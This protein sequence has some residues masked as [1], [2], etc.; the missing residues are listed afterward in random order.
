MAKLVWRQQEVIELSEAEKKRLVDELKNKSISEEHAINN[1]IAKRIKH[2]I[3]VS[4]NGSRLKLEKDGDEYYLDIYGVKFYY[5]GTDGKLTGSAIATGVALEFL[6]K[7]LLRLS[8]HVV[9]K[10]VEGGTRYE[11]YKGEAE[12][13][14]GL[15]DEDEI[16]KDEFFS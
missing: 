9:I 16:E 3:E 6:K 8:K 2:D 12:L 10:V 5:P 4:A 15:F 7:L 11:Y 14:P 1:E 13:D